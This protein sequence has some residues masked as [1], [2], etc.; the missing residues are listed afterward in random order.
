MKFTVI[1]IAVDLTAAPPTY[2]EPRTEVIDTET[3]ELFAECST[4]QDVEF[5]Y[6]KFWNY[7]NGPDHVHNRRQ[8]VKVLSVDSASS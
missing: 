8:K 4:I 1:A 3:N 6:E 7:L 5:A 2:T